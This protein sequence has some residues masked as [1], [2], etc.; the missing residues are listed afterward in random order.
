MVRESEGV[1]ISFSNYNNAFTY[2]FEEYKSLCYE[3]SNDRNIFTINKNIS[4]F[5]YDFDYAISEK[6]KRMS[7]RRDLK[8]LYRDLE[9]NTKLKEIIRRGSDFNTQIDY[10][11][12]YY[13]YLFKHLEILSTF[14]TELTY[15]F[16]PHTNIQRKLIKF[17]NNQPFFDKM[18]EFKKIVI[19]NISKFEIVSFMRGYDS[20]LTYYYA[21]G[22]FINDSVRKDIDYMLSLILS[23]MLDDE[24]LS[25]LR[26]YNNLNPIDKNR[27]LD[28]ENNIYNGLLYCNSLINISFSNYGIIPKIIKKQYVDKT[29]I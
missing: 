21:Y 11:K 29:L 12:I 15:S 27:L 24:T 17:A 26:R 28:I 23:M 14:T 3:I 13:T 2:F 18:T 16:M 25:L 9:G 6:S 22:M 1:E 5:I 10:F 7:F 19:E 20:F 4:C 8:Q